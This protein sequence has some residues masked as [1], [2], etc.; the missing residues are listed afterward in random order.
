MKYHIITYGCQMNKSD[1]ERIASFFDG[2]GFE[3]SSLEEAN[4][5]VINS[6]SIRQSAIDRMEAKIRK[7]K[8]IDHQ[9]VILTGCVLEKDKKKLAP[10]FDY[11]FPPQDTKDWDFLKKEK[12]ENFFDI[13]PKRSGITAYISI[14]TGCD[15]FCSYCVVP[16]TKG[17]E[18]SR[19]IKEVVKEAE[20]AIKKGHKEIWLLG[21]NVNSY[22]GGLTFANLL[23]KIDNIKG[24]F[25]IRFAS[26]HPKDLSLETI[27]A[28][29]DCKKVTKY[30]HLPIQSG[31]DEI[32]KKMNRPYDT[33]RYKEIIEEVRKNIPGISIS[34]D[35]IVG[36]PEETEKHFSNTVKLF[37]ELDFDMA[38]VSRYSPRAETSASKIKETVTNEEKKRR[39][40]VLEEII[41]ESAQKRNI[42]FI[43]K[44]LNLLVSRKNK[45]NYL[46][47]KTTGYQ[48]VIFKGKKDY[49]GKFTKVKITHSSSWG[50]KGTIIQK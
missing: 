2:K 30:L 22:K 43:G 6:C 21:Q 48:N 12:N 9:K 42:S 4:V 38:Y 50:L 31:D 20:E 14:M 23:R 45:S 40:K 39:E 37:R 7:I 24:D 44:N 19:G 17:R 36:F 47:G 10:F 25:W 27:N 41:K 1:S 46:I 18:R 13:T 49:I 3:E 29:R 32:L 26:S 34:T 8:K 5:I 35:V 16:Y 33:K 28:I 11:Y 15:N